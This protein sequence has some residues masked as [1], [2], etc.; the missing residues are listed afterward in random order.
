M[1]K[2]NRG[3]TLTSLIIYV[4]GMTVVVASIA[5]LTSFFYKN[6]N[7]ENDD[8]ATQFTKFSSVFAQEINKEGNRVIE[9]NT[10]D[11]VSYIIFS[12]GNQYTFVDNSIY[13]NKVKV[14]E[15]VENC[16]FS[17][18]FIDSNYKVTVNFKTSNMDLTGENA[19]TY[20]IKQ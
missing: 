3:V 20:T 15:N 13:R 10:N 19:I 7:V 12:S 18:I 17:Y 1:E 9:C 8:L 6:I 14:C 16:A 5:T 4:I 11:L 2:N